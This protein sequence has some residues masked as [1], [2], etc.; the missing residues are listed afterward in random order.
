[1]NDY[2]LAKVSPSG[3]A[4][5]AFKFGNAEENG[6]LIRVAV[7]SSNNIYIAGSFLGSVDFGTGVLTS[8]GGEDTF[9][10]AFDPLKFSLVKALWRRR[11][12]TEP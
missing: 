9:V 4:I 11:A 6:T 10:S 3:D 2:Y 7:D 12:T 5:W 1:M 8:A